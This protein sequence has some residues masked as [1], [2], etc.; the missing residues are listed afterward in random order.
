MLLEDGVLQCFSEYC[1]GAPSRHF[2]GNDPSLHY[3]SHLLVQSPQVAHVDPIF[4]HLLADLLAGEEVDLIGVQLLSQDS[5]AADDVGL[6][7]SGQRTVG[8]CQRGKRTVGL[9]GL[10]C[11]RRVCAGDDQLLA[12]KSEAGGVRVLGDEKVRQEEG[13]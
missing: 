5:D 2:R 1:L 6:R 8:R 7:E 12:E 4:V 9:E 11:Q 10:V 3:A 13:L